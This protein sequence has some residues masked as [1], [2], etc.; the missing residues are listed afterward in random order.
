VNDNTARNASWG[1]VIAAGC[2]LV[3]GLLTGCS[4]GALAVRQDPPTAVPP[5]VP[6]GS[7]AYRMQPGDQLDVK[8]YYNPELN[9]TATI[10]P[11]GKISLQLVG[12][13]QAAGLTPSVLG[14]VLTDK[15]AHELRKPVITVIVRSFAGRQIY[16]GGE[17]G[18]AGLLDLTGEGMS[19]LQAVIGAGGFKDTANPQD[20]VIL[21]R[22]S[23][24]Q[25]VSQ[26]ID[27]KAT[28]GAGFQLQPYDVVYV[29][30]S[31]IAVADQWVDQ[32]LGKLLLFRGWGVTLSNT[33][34][35]Q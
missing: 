34:V 25:Y 3:L 9:D 29:P 16:V 6:Q 2:G 27:L 30:K 12:D 33:S 26:R 15:Y 14:G 24:G 17:V 18:K 4:T 7:Q 21:R 11:D 8:F 20:V 10:R 28:N 31:G 32:Y 19:A 22:S 5:T 23:S 35:I 1:A 13:V